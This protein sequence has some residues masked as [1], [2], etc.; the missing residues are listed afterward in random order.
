MFIRDRQFINLVMQEDY[1]AIRQIFV[2][3][4]DI[5]DIAAQE[6]HRLQV[7]RQGK[8][9]DMQ[10]LWGH[11]L[12][13]VLVKEEVLRVHL[14]EVVVDIM[15][16]AM[17]CIQVAAILVEEEV[18]R[19]FPVITVVMLLVLLLLP[20]ILFTRDNPFII[21]VCLLRILL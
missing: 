16:V 20:V 10:G 15:E 19:S 7:E 6:Q 11:P 5:V 4:V 14:P 3:N 12:G 2:L 13:E 18:H 21:P 17:E 1:K 8:H 9:P